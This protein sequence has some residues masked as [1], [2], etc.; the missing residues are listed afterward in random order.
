MDTDNVLDKFKCKSDNII[1]KRKIILAWIKGVLALKQNTSNDIE[2]SPENFLEPF[3]NG[4]VLCNLMNVINNNCITKIKSEEGVFASIENLNLFVNGNRDLSGSSLNSQSPT[5]IKDSSSI[6]MLKSTPIYEENVFSPTLESPNDMKQKYNSKI[7]IIENNQSKLFSLINEINK[8]LDKIEVISNCQTNRIE[9]LA[10]NA[11]NGLDIMNQQLEAIQLR[12]EKSPAVPL[13][14]LRGNSLNNINTNG[15]QMSSSTSCITAPPEYRKQSLFF[16]SQKGNQSLPSLQNKL[17][18]GHWSHNDNPLPKSNLNPQ[19]QSQ[20]SMTPLSASESFSSAPQLQYSTLPENI[21][22]MNLSRQENMRLSVIYELF[23]TESDYCRD[24]NVIINCLMDNISK[25]QLLTEKEFNGLFSNV[26]DLIVVNQEFNDNLTAL[27]EADPVIPEIGNEFLKI[28][29]KLKT[30]KEYCSNYP[31]ALSLLRELNQKPEIKALLTIKPVQRIC[32]YP[33][34]I[35]EL[36]KYTS[37]ESKDY[38]VLENSLTVIENVIAYVNEGT[39]ALEE[40]ERLSGLQARIELSEFPDIQLKLADKH[41]I[42]EGNIQRL[43]NSKPKDRHMFLFNDC[44]LICKDWTASYKYKYQLEEF[45]PIDSIILKNEI[46][47]KLPKGHTNVFQLIPKDTRS[48]AEKLQGGDLNKQ[49]IT[50]SLLTELQK[51]EWTQSIWDAITESKKAHR[52]AETANTDDDIDLDIE[53]EIKISIKK[54]EEFPSLVEFNGVKW[55]KAVAATG[56]N[57]YFNTVTFDS[58][59]KLPNEYYIIDSETGEKYLHN[60]TEIEEARRTEME[61]DDDDDSNVEDEYYNSENVEGYPDWKMVKMDNNIKYYFNINTKESQWEHPGS[62]TD[63]DN[64]NNTNDKT[65]IQQLQNI[66]VNVSPTQ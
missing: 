51:K 30:Y 41:M 60:E 29:E 33:L 9:K 36:I 52:E 57:Y 49:P 24:L 66:L 15:L 64:S 22:Q 3:H 18:F 62:S 14:T 40:K 55:K 56:Q 28:A 63:N 6:S 27:K 58:I 38:P 54:K 50:L 13:S 42:K 21:I 12:L 43:I 26:K 46:K 17:K 65:S 25:S 16:G 31:L 11:L 59:W 7:E 32:K 37:K 39:K 61:D 47:E 2:F 10:A 19:S 34:M 48:K 4:V 8:K 1:S 5:H 20:L 45:L 44:I 23:A 53:E 35:R